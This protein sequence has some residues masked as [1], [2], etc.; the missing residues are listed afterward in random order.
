MISKFIKKKVKVLRNLSY[1]N[2]I[3]LPTCDTNTTMNILVIQ[4]NGNGLELK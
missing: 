4:S 2:H 1:L 3:I